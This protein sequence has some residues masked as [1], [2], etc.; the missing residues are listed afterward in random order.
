MSLT[1][2]FCYIYNYIIFKIIK[3]NKFKNIYFHGLDYSFYDN[4]VTSIKSETSVNLNQ[5]ANKYLNPG[6][7]IEIAVG[8]IE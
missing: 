3:E 4:F 5:I 1:F 8:G 7:M 2:N 6:Q